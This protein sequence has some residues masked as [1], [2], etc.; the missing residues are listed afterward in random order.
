MSETP[1][2]ARG[3][4]SSHAIGWSPVVSPNAGVHER[5]LLLPDFARVRCRFSERLRVYL[6]LRDRL[7]PI[8]FKGT[9]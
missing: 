4:S 1:W 6:H 5:L 9:G 2:Q 3:P 7:I 8:F